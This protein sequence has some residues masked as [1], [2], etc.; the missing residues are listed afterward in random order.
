MHAF[1][2]SDF[3]IHSLQAQEFRRSW[4]TAANNAEIIFENVNILKRDIQVRIHAFTFSI[5]SFHLFA[6]DFELFFCVFI[7]EHLHLLFD[8]PGDRERISH[9]LSEIQVR[10]ILILYSSLLNLSLHVS[11]ILTNYFHCLTRIPPNP[12]STVRTTH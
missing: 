8:I 6:S 11:S 10:F 12:S 2:I 4:T 3:F 5:I 1:P 9:C 7:Q